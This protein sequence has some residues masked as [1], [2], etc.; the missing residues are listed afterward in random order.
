MKK[1]RAQKIV[2]KHKCNSYPR[3]TDSRLA[4]LEVLMRH[5]VNNDIA[6]IWLVLKIILTAIISAAGTVLVKVLFKV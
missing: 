1:T 5:L 2:E 6:H 4:V 3:T